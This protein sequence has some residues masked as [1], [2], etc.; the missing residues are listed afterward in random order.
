M[1]QSRRLAGS[2]LTASARGLAGLLIGGR[3]HDLA[4]Q[5]FER[6]AVGDEARGQVV[7][8]LRMGRLLALGAEIAGRLDQRLAEVPAPDAIDDDAGG[9]RSGVGEDLLGQFQ[10]ARAVV[11]GGVALGQHGQETRAAPVRRAWRHCRRGARAG[12][13]AR[14]A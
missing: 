1:R 9:E 14:R 8:Q 10:P 12:R 7:E 11:K 6:P 5:P 13:A 3:E 4:V 2:I